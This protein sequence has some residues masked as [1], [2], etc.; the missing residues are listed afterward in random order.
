MDQVR[1]D[2]CTQAF[3]LALP[4]M[5]EDQVK[6]LILISTIIFRIV[7]NPES[8]EQFMFVYYRAT[9]EKPLCDKIYYHDECHKH[10]KLKM[11]YLVIGRVLLM[12]AQH[13]SNVIMIRIKTHSKYNIF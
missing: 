12:L 11:T 1:K 2:K 10:Y 3:N 4:T 6:M 8:D 7:T 13:S 5:G 9:N